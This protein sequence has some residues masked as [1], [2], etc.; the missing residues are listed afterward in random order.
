MAVAHYHVTDLDL[1]P[2]FAEA[3]S[4]MRAVATSQRALSPFAAPP[5]MRQLVGLR[6][7]M[8]LVLRPD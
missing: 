3:L 1:K 7:G 4:H 8:L 5:L 2:V 6:P